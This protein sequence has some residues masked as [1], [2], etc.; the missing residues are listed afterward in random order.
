[1][2]LLDNK[3][4]F[5]IEEIIMC[6]PYRTRNGITIRGDQALKKAFEKKFQAEVKA[7]KEARK[8]VIQ[9]L[10][11]DTSKTRGELIKVLQQRIEVIEAERSIDGFVLEGKSKNES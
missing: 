4:N 6:M 5:N 11:H 9:F 8:D 10:Y 3:D 1:L 7:T 2:T